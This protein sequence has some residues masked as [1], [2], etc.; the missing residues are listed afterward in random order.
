MLGRASICS[1]HYFFSLLGP[2]ENATLADYYA[3]LCGC[4]TTGN[5]TD[6]ELT[7]GSTRFRLTEFCTIL[8]WN[9]S[10]AA[11]RRF[12]PTAILRLEST[13]IQR[14]TSPTTTTVPA[15]Q[16]RTTAHLNVHLKFQSC[17]IVWIVRWP[18]MGNMAR[19][20]HRRR[21]RWWLLSL[22]CAVPSPRVPSWNHAWRGGCWAGGSD[23]C[24]LAEYA[25]NWI[26][27]MFSLWVFRAHSMSWFFNNSIWA[28]L[29]NTMFNCKID[30]ISA[31]NVISPYIN[32][33]TCSSF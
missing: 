1:S 15:V 28:K 22:T 5:C 6:C 16:Q 13:L 10:R 33:T 3:L 23:G 29:F 11:G 32:L 8:Q 4:H 26:E 27:S 31:E 30:I 9:A 25:F 7:G 17:R 18:N 24:K 19:W 21:R 20:W 14:D 12:E 2:R